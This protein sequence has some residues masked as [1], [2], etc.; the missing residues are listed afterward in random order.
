M[1]DKYNRDVKAFLASVRKKHDE[2]WG[3]LDGY[4]EMVN[5]IMRTQNRICAAG[6]VQSEI[7]VVPPSMGKSMCS[8]VQFVIDW[9]AEVLENGRKK[10]VMQFTGKPKDQAAMIFSAAQGAMQYGRA[11]GEKKSR[12]VMKQIKETVKPR[13]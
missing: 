2:P 4:I 11:Q 1:A 8:L 9:I 6:S 3:Q 7:N 5:G 13:R 10:G 12:V